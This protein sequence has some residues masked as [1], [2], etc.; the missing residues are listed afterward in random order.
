MIDNN[1]SVLLIYTG[2]TIGMTENPETGHLEPFNFSL[3]KENVPDL[4]RFKFQI[5]T[6]HFNPPIDSSDMTPDYWRKLVQI[7]DENYQKYD[8]FVILHGTD[9]MAYTASALSFMLENLDKP[10]VF[11]G[12]QLPIGKLRTDGKENLI[13]AL[14]IAVDKD[15]DTGLPFVPEVS[16]FFQNY[17]MRGNRITKINTDNFSA[18]RSPNYRPLARSGVNIVYEHDLIIQPKIRNSLQCH[19]LLN[20]HVTILKLFPGI[21]PDTVN[22]I[23]NIPGLQGVV[24]ETY[25][26]GNAPNHPW[27]L[28]A[29]KDA[30]RRGI[31]II[32]VTQCQIGSVEMSR[33]KS[34]KIL[35]ESGVISGL[36]ITTEAAVTKLMFLL[37][38][39]KTHEEVRNYMKKSLIGEVTEN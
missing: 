32:N 23:L 30:V 33:Y 31:M 17:L 1:A 4:R 15:P 11:T 26:N 27:L 12:S 22:G 38:H 28:D 6:I 7:I 18:F 2:G 25:G 13:T 39:N 24:L 16:V 37:G 3:L 9:T 8:G 14:E 36:D 10:V 35:L 21:S 34:G 5:E 29:I 19:Y 20:T